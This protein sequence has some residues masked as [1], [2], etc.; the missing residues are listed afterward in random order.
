MRI[1]IDISQIVYEGTGVGTYVKK[2]VETLLA[3]DSRNT[4]VLFGSS[5]RQQQKFKIFFE[6]LRQIRSGLEL[7]VVPLPP[8]VLDFLWNRLHIFP[9]ENFI[10]HVDIFWSSDWT[11]P[12]LR[13]AKGVTTV[14]DVSFVLY[15]KS[16]AR[17]IIDVQKRRLAQ[18]KK[19]CV[20]IFCDSGCTKKDV[21]RLF[22]IDPKKLLVLYPGY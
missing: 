13:S 3:Y 7:K 11:Q 5:F 14:H 20:A 2:L 8:A 15:P 1:G 4:Y 16:F 19:E 17:N 12:P 6:H 21:S 9:I 18:V 10:G 22:N